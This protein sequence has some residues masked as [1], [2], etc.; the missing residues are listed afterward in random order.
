MFVVCCLLLFLQHHPYPSSLGSLLFLL[1]LTSLSFVFN[2]S[3]YVSSLPQSARSMR[4]RERE[5]E[6]E[7]DGG[8]DV[9][10]EERRH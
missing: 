1:F 8:S 3:S 10:D 4:D 9:E 6:R 2:S 5:R 7:L